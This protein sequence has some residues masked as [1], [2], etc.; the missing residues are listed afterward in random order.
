MPPLTEPAG[1]G[2][3]PCGRIG[4]PLELVPLPES[5]QQG[6]LNQILRFVRASAHPHANTKE[7][8]SHPFRDIREGNVAAWSLSHTPTGHSLLDSI[9]G[10]RWF[11]ISFESAGN[12]GG[13]ESPG[14][15]IA[16][17]DRWQR[18]RSQRTTGNGYEGL[19]RLVHA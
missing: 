13:S 1:D 2:V 17:R 15:R 7:T 10:L 3:E 18:L 9:E 6:V 19:G 16:R 5:L 12:G 14:C 4:A 8:R 11:T